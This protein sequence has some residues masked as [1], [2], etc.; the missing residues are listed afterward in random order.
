METRI[1]RDRAADRINKIDAVA[2][3]VAGSDQP[4]MLNHDALQQRVR[5]K[6]VG[7]GGY[8]VARR[9]S[10]QGVALDGHVNIACPV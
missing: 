8:G 6:G 3:G 2:P 7:D 5:R 9:N 10:D 1:G 4:I